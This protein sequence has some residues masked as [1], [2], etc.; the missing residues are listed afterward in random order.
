MLERRHSAWP[1]VTAVTVLFVFVGVLLVRDQTE[2]A[3]EEAASRAVAE[4]KTLDRIAQ[5]STITGRRLME[6]EIG[7][8]I[9]VK[10]DGRQQTYEVRIG[11]TSSQPEFEE[12]EDD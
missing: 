6:A 11:L 1:A 9:R 7:D 2:S 8:R 5:E 3:S 10:L 4:A 12:V